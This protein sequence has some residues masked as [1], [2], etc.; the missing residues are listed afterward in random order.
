[1]T[2][3]LL[4]L[5]PIALIDST[6]LVPMA[7]VP[8]LVMLGGR[9]PF[10]T[11]MTFIAAV[12]VS[13]VACGILIVFGLSAFVDGAAHW[14]K[15]YWSNPYVIEIYVQIVAG[16]LILIFA[17]KVGEKST[18]KGQ[19]QA[20]AE[21]SPWSAFTFGAILTVGGIWG[22]LPYFAAIAEIE[23]AELS[24][25]DSVVALVYYNIVFALP[26]IAIVVVR[27]VA[28]ERSDTFFAKLR[29]FF[30]KWTKRL[31]VSGLMLLGILLFLDGIG[32]LLGWPLLPTGT[33]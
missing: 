20:P 31:V 22:A 6:S 3:L 12:F 4:L 25:L 1:M 11:A 15:N 24:M 5:T 29:D 19:K 30:T 21:M 32:W 27:Q 16:F 28:G 18:P 10:L 14:A 9:R 23:Q 7:I 2:A 17:V 26:L 8:M 33:P 13:Y